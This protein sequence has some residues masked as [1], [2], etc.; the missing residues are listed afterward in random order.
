MKTDQMPATAPTVRP[1]RRE[2]LLRVAADLFL[3]KPYDS[4][5]VEMICAKA[6]ISAPGLYRHFQKDRKS[7]V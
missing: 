1:S 7:V 5:T 2:L 6:G 4:V 3:H